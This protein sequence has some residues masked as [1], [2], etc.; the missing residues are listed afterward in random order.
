MAD[1]RVLP[2]AEFVLVG[3]FHGKLDLFLEFI[4]TIQP[5]H[6]PIFVGDLIDK[7]PMSLG[8]IK[9]IIAFNQQRKQ[10]G[11]P[12]IVVARGNHE[13]L[14]LEY[15]RHRSTLKPGKEHRYFH[16]DTGGK[17]VKDLDESQL[18]FLADYFST[19]PYIVRTPQFDVAHAR[20]P[21][22]DR[23]LTQR[24]AAGNFTLTDKEKHSAIWDRPEEL[25][26][27]YTLDSIMSRPVYVGHSI[28]GGVRRCTNHINID[29]GAY[30]YGNLCVVEP[31][32]G[33]C[34]LI[35]NAARRTPGMLKVV[36]DIIVHHAFIKTMKKILEIRD[37]PESE[38]KSQQINAATAEYAIECARHTKQP[39][40]DFYFEILEYYVI[41]VLPKAM[42]M[43]LRAYLKTQPEFQAIDRPKK[44]LAEDDII[45]PGCEAKRLF[46]LEQDKEMPL[47][48]KGRR[49]WFVLATIACKLPTD[50]TTQSCI[51]VLSQ[52]REAYPD[53]REL[54]LAV[55]RFLVEFYTKLEIDNR[56]PLRFFSDP[57][58]FMVDALASLG[59]NLVEVRNEKQLAALKVKDA[60]AAYGC[61][62][63]TLTQLGFL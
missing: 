6:Q 15:Y 45:T 42:G 57:P 25:I 56:R 14:F 63:T 39:S 26:E 13:E 21:M 49:I 8:L 37:A 30:A 24:I 53:S 46:E 18:K 43:A 48:T 1:I 5:H 7:G 35:G 33:S 27:G 16:P 59:V 2:E 17:W 10:L 50:D 58:P 40:G 47:E 31:H 20:R 29:V 62:E 32:K 3:D 22:S 52:F 36:N 11:L 41:P 23:E 55:G 9:A 38:E 34:V 4:K 60:A 54:V 28:M 12:E 19:L 51:K 61:D 44:V